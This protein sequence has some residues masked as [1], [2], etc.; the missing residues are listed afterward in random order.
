MT[1]SI[2]TIWPMFGIANQLLAA[3]ALCVATTVIVNEGRARFAW[4]TILPLAFV[5]T[6]TLTAGWLSIVNNFLP[7]A[8]SGGKP[9]LGYLNATLTAL[10]ML[11]A[12]IILTNSAWKWRS[13]LRSRGTVSMGV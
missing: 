4:V 12:V 2:S 6:T 10:M 3:V 5:A 8:R 11:C 1:G 13:V 7:L 9:L